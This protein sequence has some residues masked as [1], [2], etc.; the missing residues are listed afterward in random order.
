MIRDLDFR[1]KVA[2]TFSFREEY[3]KKDL[4]DFDIQTR[5]ISNTL[6]EF[7]HLSCM[8]SGSSLPACLK[9]REGFI[10]NF[11]N[12]LFT[13]L[14]TAQVR[15]FH[16]QIAVRSSNNVRFLRDLGASRPFGFTHLNVHRTFIH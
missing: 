12:D 7:G 10:E 15:A 4:L 1:N 8:F 13:L 5:E 14:R 6:A 2:S 9:D 16:L 3:I 11:H